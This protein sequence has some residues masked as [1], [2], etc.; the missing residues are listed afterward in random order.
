[1]TLPELC[2]AWPGHKAPFHMAPLPSHGLSEGGR[3][4][5][6]CPNSSRRRLRLRRS[7]ACAVSHSEKG[8]GGVRIYNSGSFCVC[9]MFVVWVPGVFVGGV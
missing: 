4:D 2:S 8:Q 5:I 7:M 6:N 9:M 3:E 1:M